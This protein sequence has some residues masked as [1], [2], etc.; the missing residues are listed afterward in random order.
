MTNPATF[1]GLLPC[2]NYEDAGAALD[3]LAA[4]FGFVERARYVDGDGLVRQAEIHVGDQELWLAGRG[5]GY[6]S[7][8]GGRPDLWLGV[9][10]DDVDAQ[11]ARVRA[12]GVEADAP[13]D[14]D[15]DVRSFNVFDPEGY[16][17]GFLKRL[18]VDYVQT[19]PTEAGGLREIL[20][21]T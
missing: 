2:L 13:A 8:H 16:H 9:W 14:Q 21:D 5:A 6:W 4:T 17:W 11:Y 15:Y 1:N 10:V 19:I 20:P 7:D 12:A 3:W 18:G